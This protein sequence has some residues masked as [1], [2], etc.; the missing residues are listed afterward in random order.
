[1]P[2]RLPSISTFRYLYLDNNRLT[3]P[4]PDEYA[5]MSTASIIFRIS[6]NNLDRDTSNNALISP[7]L[8]TWWNNIV[9]YN[10]DPVNYKLISSQ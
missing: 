8:Q 9:P 5:N 4:I 10:N 3:G 7:A 1:M 2:K 6:N